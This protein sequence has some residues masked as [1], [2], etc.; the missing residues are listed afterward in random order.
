MACPRFKLQQYGLELT[1]LDF[2]FVA[3]FVQH[4]IQDHAATASTLLL[5]G[6]KPHNFPRERLHLSRHLKQLLHA[7]PNVRLRQRKRRLR[8]RFVRRGRRRRRRLRAENYWCQ[9]WRRRFLSN[10]LTAVVSVALESLVV[11][12]ADTSRRHAVLEVITVL[13]VVVVVCAGFASLTAL[14]STRLLLSSSNGPLTSRASGDGAGGA[15]VEG[16]A[17]PVNRELYGVVVAADEKGCERVRF[18]ALVR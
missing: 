15:R 18:G 16:A 12:P 13:V 17:T 6:G 10:V 2:V 5:A 14:T 8:I 1:Q 7:P 4:R 11:F 3:I 9:R